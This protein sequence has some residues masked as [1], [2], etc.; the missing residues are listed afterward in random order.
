MRRL[1]LL[2]GLAGL[3]I[4]ATMS[5]GPGA[6]V[7]AKTPRE[8]AVELAT[9]MVPRETYRQT[10]HQLAQGL[11]A[12]AQN[13]GQVMPADFGSQIEAVVAEALPYDEQVRLTA[14]VYAS[15]FSEAEI[16]ELGAFYKTPTGTKL[17]KEL[18]AVTEDLGT[19]LGS[20]LPERLPALMKKHGI[21]P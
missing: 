11:I 12:G 2:F 10:I 7:L 14:D 17:V 16:N 19:K 8:A 13:S 1:Y 21:T 9:L 4:F 5:L 3:V 15:R 6:P 20:L 18:P